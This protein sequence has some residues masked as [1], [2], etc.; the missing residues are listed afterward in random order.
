MAKKKNK[1]NKTAFNKALKPFLKNNQ[2][3]L[4]VL[5]AAAGGAAL[6]ALIGSDK[7]QRIIDDLTVSV[8]DMVQ[9][10]G[11]GLPSVKQG[12]KKPTPAPVS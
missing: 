5:G 7:A 8:K 1:G 12:T 9:K 6:A 4:T 10:N 11:Q 3:L 2:M